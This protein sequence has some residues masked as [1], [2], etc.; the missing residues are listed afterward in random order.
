MAVD[1]RR[2]RG[3]GLAGRAGFGGG[4]G[5]YSIITSLMTATGRPGDE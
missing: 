5:V 4:G 3:A 1:Y 2:L